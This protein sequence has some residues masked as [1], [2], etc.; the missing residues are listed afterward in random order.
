MRQRGSTLLIVLVLVGATTTVVIAAADLVISSMTS[1]WRR[2]HAVH[3][4][5]VA[6]AMVEYIQSRRAKGTLSLPTTLNRTIDGSDVTATIQDNS[7]NLKRSLLV[8]ITV[9]EG[10]MTFKES[11]VVGDG[12]APKHFYYALASHQTLDLPNSLTTTSPGHRGHVYVGN[13]LNITSLGVTIDGDL[14]VFRNLTG[15]ASVSGVTW[16]GVPKIS[17]PTPNPLLYAVGAVLVGAGSVGSHTFSNTALVYE[18]L[19]A[20]GDA[21]IQGTFGGRGVVFVGKNIRITGDIY[22]KDDNALIAII[23]K[24]DITVEANVKHIDGFLYAGGKFTQK[25]ANLTVGRGAIVAKSFD[26]KGNLVVNYDHAVWDDPDVGW[27]LKLP[28][29]FP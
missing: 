7:I 15:S 21:D 29:F 26:L 18:T 27:R 20:I 3:A 2:Y 9:E 4:R 19:Y 13:D 28:G 6:D 24:D 22:Y 17:W 10:G 23:A 14:E 12:F 11:R 1:Q 16:L 5:Y 25:G 8:E